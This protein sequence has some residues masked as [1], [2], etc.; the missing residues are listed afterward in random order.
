MDSKSKLNAITYQNNRHPHLKFS[1]VLFDAAETLFTTRGSVGEIYAAVARRYGSQ[2]E[3]ALI[4]EAF[5]R[6]FHGA[7]PV[8]VE[9][10]KRWWKDLVFRVFSE[11]GMV[12]NFDQFFDE[13][14]ERFRG[15]QGWIL[16][17]ETVEVLERLKGLGLKLGIISNFDSRVYSVLDSLGIRKFFDA[18]TL[19]SE[20]GYCKPAPQIFEAAVQALGVPASE[21]LLIGDSPH[22]DIEAGLRAGLSAVL[23]DRSGR[24]AS[25]THLER[26]SS[27]SEVEGKIAASD[28]F[29]S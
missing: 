23:I 6:Q 12:E 16:F 13:V 5:V 1:A 4:Q 25:K 14:Y 3:P 7:G 26:I 2:T 17:P 22:D 11:V 20:A 18:I 8:S 15:S 24:H 29:P 10:Q 28:R 21:V 27:L 9:D 19:S